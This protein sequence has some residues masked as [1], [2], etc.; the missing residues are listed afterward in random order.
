V[1]EE[2]GFLNI[3]DPIGLHSPPEQQDRERELTTD[4]RRRQRPVFP[5]SRKLT[6][7]FGCGDELATS[8]QKLASHSKKDNENLINHDLWDNNS[9]CLGWFHHARRIK[10]GGYMTKGRGKRRE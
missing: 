7:P 3:T 8:P 2:E 10:D 9:T 6:F 5:Q 1:E 4:G